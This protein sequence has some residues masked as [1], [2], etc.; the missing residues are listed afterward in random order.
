MRMIIV[1]G[2]SGSGKT[3]ALQTLEDLNDYCVDN[4]PLDLLEPFAEMVRAKES[5]VFSTT[6]VGIDARNFRDGLLRFPDIVARLRASALVVEILFLQAADEVLLKRY[7]ETRRRH[8]LN[9][10]GKPLLETIR[11]ERRLLEPIAA[12]ADLVIDTSHSNVH[13]LRELVRTRLHDTPQGEVS[14]LFESF[15]FKYGIPADADFMFDVRCLPNPHW[16]PQLRPLTGL[17]PKVAEYLESDPGVARMI[18]D[19]TGFLEAWIPRFETGSR[20]YL[21]VAI[22]CTGG[23]HRS[24]FIADTLARHFSRTRR[25]VTTRHRE[26]A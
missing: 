24:V 8:P 16:E 4:L 12:H 14:V 26:L 18:E 2:L 22:G 23:Q 10:E 7:S 13:E 21:T 6:A 25:N 20:S 17:D 3:I 19:L 9:L 15:G 1:S 11:A 5:P